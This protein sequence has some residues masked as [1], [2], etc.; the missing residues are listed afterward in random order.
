VP[1]L[2]LCILL[3]VE[4]LDEGPRGAAQTFIVAHGAGGGMDTPF[5]NRIARGVAAKDIRVIR[6]EFPY[7]RRRREEGRPTGAPDRQPALIQAWREVIEAY[8]TGTKLFI[9]GK[10]MGGRIATIVADE[11]AVAGVVCLGYPFHPP[12]APQKLRTAHLETLQ[13]PTLIV[14]G[15]RDPF[16]TRQE[17]ASY[18]LSECI[19]IEWMPDGDHSFKPRA[20]SGLHE[21]QNLD[22]AIAAVSAF[23]CR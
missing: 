1:N 6:F 22:H 7:M 12:G 10:S 2:C 23:I 20:S 5:M 11:A 17:V 14:Q 4:V 13:T 19:R 18:A 9:G 16:G 15:E 8:R 3:I 21:T